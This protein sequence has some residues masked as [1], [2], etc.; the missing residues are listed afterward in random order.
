MKCFLIPFCIWRSQDFQYQRLT[1]EQSMMIWWYS[2]RRLFNSIKIYALHSQFLYEYIILY[3]L[4]LC[5]SVKS[6]SE[7]LSCDFASSCKSGRLNLLKFAH[8]HS[9][10]WQTPRFSQVDACDWWHMIYL[11]SDSDPAARVV[12]FYRFTS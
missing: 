6:R 2:T 12:A 10:T 8:K 7:V 1:I 4:L 5:H 11:N 9:F 3:K